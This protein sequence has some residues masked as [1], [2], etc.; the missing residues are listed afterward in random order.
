VSISTTRDTPSAFGLLQVDFVGAGAA[1]GAGAGAGACAVWAQ[2]VTVAD[3]EIATAIAKALRIKFSI[4][5]KNP[6]SGKSITN[7]GFNLWSGRCQRPR[8]RRY[9]AAIEQLITESGREAALPWASGEP[10]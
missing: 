10:M 2:A 7:R 4:R 8:Y 1:A 9:F 5:G 6:Y 3:S